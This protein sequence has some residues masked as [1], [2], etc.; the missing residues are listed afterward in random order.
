MRLERRR[1]IVT[2]G[3]GFI[4]SHVVAELV[5]RGSQ[6]AVIDDLS[7]GSVANLGRHLRG[8]APNGSS[9]PSEVE[10]VEAD[11][12]DAAAMD[13]LIA[14]ADLVLHMAVVCTRTG[15]TRPELVNEVNATGTLNVALAALRNRVRRLVVISSSEVYG[16]AARVPMDEDHPT[17]PTTVHGASKLAGEAYASSIART[18]GLEVTV[19][20]PFNG[21][22]PRAPHEGDRAE[23]IPRF[24][25]R[26][27]AGGRP[28]IFGSG[29][30][31]RD[32]TWVG[33]IAR[34]IASAAAADDLVGET[35]NLARGREVTIRQL[36]EKVLAIFGRA[37]ESPVY[38]DPRPGDI[39]RQLGDPS[40]ATRLIG[41]RP[42][43]SI[44]EGLRRYVDWVARQPVDAQRWL[45][46]NEWGSW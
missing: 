40:K 4:G 8:A 17:R 34:G 30:Q 20:R 29:L 37:G 11:V 38:H 27:M 10:L 33:D 2:G 25:L 36:A 19:V 24:V 12:R 23:V 22:G 9:P 35:V 18:H 3:A 45:A 32:F 5:S 28:I 39:D 16:S 42:A 7:A 31:T 6:V 46:E 43:V 14:D 41:W 13:R 1:V 44:D 15:L 21:Y 26:T